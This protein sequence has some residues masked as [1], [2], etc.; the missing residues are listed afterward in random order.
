M[1]DLPEKTIAIREISGTAAPEHLLGRFHGLRAGCKRLKEGAIHLLGAAQVVREREPPETLPIGRD[2]GILGQQVR[3]IQR[4]PE[5][6]FEFA[7]AA[8]ELLACNRE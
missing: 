2:G 5:G 7:A 4:Q 3:G 8:F 6:T 1:R